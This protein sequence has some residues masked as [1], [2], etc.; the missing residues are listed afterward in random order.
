MLKKLR[1]CMMGCL[2]SGTALGAEVFEA[3]NGR[4]AELPKGKEAD[5][6]RGDFVLRSDKVEALVS[7]NAHNR[8]ANMSTFYG[9]DG[10]TPGCLYDLALRGSNND[11]LICY[12]PTGHG[13]VSYV[14]IAD[15][16]G[17]VE[18]VITAAKNKGIY[19]RHEYR[20]KD[21]DSG[22]WITT[23][24]RNEGREAQKVST[25]DDFVRFNDSGTA[26]GIKWYSVVDPN[27]KAGYALV[28]VKVTGAEKADDSVSIDP[29]KEVLIERF[30]AVGTSALQAWGYAAEKRGDKLGKVTG[31]ISDKD[32]QPVGTGRLLVKLGNSEV[33][34]YPDSSGKVDLLLP[35]GELEAA[36]QDI[37]RENAAV[38]LSVKEGGTTTFQSVMTPAAKVVFKIT[39][40]QGRSLPCKAMFEGV[41]GTPQPDLGPV[42]RAHG[43]KDQWHSETG[44]FSV[45]LPAGSYKVR[46]VRGLEYRSI[47]QD[48]TIAP[49]KPANVTG[50]LQ[51]V[52]DTK[53]WISADFHNHSTQSGDNIC[54]TDDRLIN[55]GAENIELAP[56]TEHNRFY[57]WEPHIK[58]LGLEPW[59]K[60][61]KGIELTG[62][63]QH[64]NSFPFEP[65]PYLQDGGAP[66]WN[67]D[68]R[69]TAITLR[70]HQGENPTRW[71]QFNHPDLSN[72]FHDR[73][74]DG[75]ADGGFVG[76]GQLIDG[77]ETQNGNETNILEGAPYRITRAPGSL[78]SRASQVREF[79]WLQLLNQGLRAT[80]VAVAD[81]HAVYGNGVAGW[82]TYL[83]S[84][85]DN[86]AE[87]SWDELSPKA[88][89]GQILLTNGPFLS[90][91]TPDGQGPG[92]EVNAAGSIRLHVKVQCTDWVGI[93]RVQI[94]V[95]SRPD[96]KLNFTRAT[97]A[98]M[99]KDGV[100]QF[101]NN[102]DVPLQKDAHLIVVA[103]GENGDLAGGYGTSSQAKMKPCAYI[104]PI[105][106]DVDGHGFT[107]NGDTLGYEL[108]VMGATADKAREILIRGGKLAPPP[109]GE[110]PKP[111]AK[112]AKS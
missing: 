99:F 107:A 103:M 33:W 97:H 41:N 62:R 81:A 28:V 79:L 21:G 71:I 45:A 109:A 112:P 48:V 58:K 12:G 42:M 98:K 44:S 36:A 82:L 50:V 39:D 10:V 75:I 51:R 34:A 105:Y 87:I 69:I 13:P 80:A 35:A 49:G 22:I 31:T 77:L 29:G 93:D 94:L 57:D 110:T 37:G 95:N 2:I 65:D 76:V 55:I 73:D 5:G 40:E 18:T 7:K 60:T 27:D 19:K 24:L 92:A 4:E 85:T 53:G 52:V 56:T 70:R 104:N 66:E 32:G 72:M 17:S 43:C 47:V 46:V 86:P 9:E 106:V 88:K 30:L 111:D 96:P 16:K 89:G 78:T 64:F 84:S 61:V 14:R 26:Q 8:R 11:Q 54:G 101:D 68:P 23:T 91:K 102:I 83:P 15:E 63:R 74:G 3:D 90:V 25:K 67:D 20:V 6:I 108:P 59:I 38:A 1:Y 100:V